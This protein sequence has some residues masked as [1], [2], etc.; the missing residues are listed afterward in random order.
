MEIVKRYFASLMVGLL[1]AQTPV[2][3]FAAEGDP[4]STDPAASPSPAADTVAPSSPVLNLVNSTQTEVD[5]SFSASTDN[6][7]VTGYTLIRNGVS[8]ATVNAA[9]TRY[10]DMNATANTAYAYVL[11]AFDAAGNVS[12]LSNEVDVTTP[13]NVQAETAAPATGS[14]GQSTGT[15][16][17][18]TSSPATTGSGT[19]AQDNAA[20]PTGNIPTYAFNDKTRKWEPTITSSF[21]W[22]SSVMLYTSPFYRYDKVTG[23]YH[24]V[25][26]I[27][28]SEAIAGLTANSSDP[29][30]LLAAILG[31]NDPSNN[32]TGPNSINNA[33]QNTANS[34][35][36]R[37][38]NNVSVTNNET[39]VANS[40]D[41]G[42]SSNTNGGSA[43]TGAAKVV[44]NLLNLLNSMWTWS[45]GGFNYFM[46]NI[47]GNQTGD[48][49]LTSAETSGGG[50]QVGA[51]GCLGELSGNTNTGPSSTNTASSQCANDITVENK[52]AGSITNN[53]D[54]LAHSGNASVSSNTNGGNATSG[55]ARAELNIVNLINSAIGADQT[56]FGI[57]NIYGNLNGDIL[58]P[59]LGLNGSVASSAPNSS[60][61]NNFTGPNSTNT[62]ANN[63]TNNAD[64][65]NAANQTVNNNIRTGAVSGSANVSGNT[66]A[67]DATSGDATTNN[68]VFNLFDTSVFGDNA[69][70]VIIND[71][72]HWIGKLMNLGVNGFSGSGLLTSNASVSINQNTGPNSV[73]DA[74]NS[75]DNNLTIDN[76]P[77]ETITN[78]VRAAAISGN[79]DVTNNT[80]A[81]N[82]TSGDATVSTN[83]ANILGSHLS[84][85]KIFGILII[86]VFGSWFGDVGN[87]TAAGNAPGRGSGAPVSAVHQT[88]TQVTVSSQTNTH[89]SLAANSVSGGSGT[90]SNTTSATTSIA[91][92]NTSLHAPNRSAL[93]VA[94]ANAKSSTNVLFGIS[95]LIMIIAGAL[96]AFERKL[97][98]A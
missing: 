19:T 33:N 5:L 63:S 92:T 68:A 89:P 18:G 49:N 38:L 59:T 60:V 96:A 37:L 62:A 13:P 29:A 98:K 8:I 69:V 50:G 31:L 34:L 65:T 51:I 73:N 82:A 26:N 12:P 70:L 93:A 10:S 58:F 11:S 21:A 40:G 97:K 91:S 88:S 24:V 74:S 80:K 86:N 57:F 48:I 4:S 28:P 41:A 17:T 95:L 64:I 47:Y 7:G 1:L 6:V 55:D 30:A 23:W 52:S 16:S 81:G 22:D 44:S 25:P 14:S 83:V 94:T 15:D 66:S 32:N 20:R 75:T 71:M 90:G 67:G 85:K 77:T 53:V 36:A 46:H 84:F 2:V 39:S 45:S 76:S 78:N 87:N 42:V 9:A 72:G 3:V 43:A 27:T 54:L 79:A 61:S 35:L 56:F